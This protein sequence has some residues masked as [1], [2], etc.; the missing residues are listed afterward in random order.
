MS[1]K[2]KLYYLNGRGKMESI[3][4]LLAAAGV[5][6]EEEFLKTR[7]QFEALVQDGLSLRFEQIPLVQMDGM[8]LRQTKGIL[9]YIAG[10]YN[11][12]RK[13]LNVRLFIDMYVDGIRDLLTMC[14]VFIVNAGKDKQKANIKEKATNRYFPQYE[15]VRI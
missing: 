10:K 7:E 9:S 11:M 14:M 8:N 4:W 5:E 2:P 3:R 12:Y 1:Q 13:Y 6:F 15:K